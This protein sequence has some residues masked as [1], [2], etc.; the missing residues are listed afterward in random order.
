MADEISLKLEEREVTGKQV[1]HLRKD[2]LVPAV[3]HDHGKPSVHVMAPYLE[4][5]KVYREAGKHHPIS[6]S[7]GSQTYTALI[8]TAEFEPRK[9]R[10]NHVVFGAV[11][12]D[13]KVT[14]EIPIR[15]SEDIPAEKASLI[16]I[17][18]LESVEVEALP[19]DLPDEFI[20]NA[21]SLIEI[22]DKLT[23]ADIIAPA[24]V[25]IL[26]EPEHAIATVYEPSALAAANDA[27]GGDAEPE[28][29][30]DVESEE[31][32]AEAD[33]EN[34]ETQAEE[35]RPGGKEQKESHDQGTNPE[36]Q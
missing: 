6:L 12:A 27:A 1:K 16:V 36:K 9:H 11:S 14:T 23:V 33:A 26:T 5:F 30:A 35:I 4:V 24:S 3:I 8:K 34:A 7:V 19:K 22:G 28:D 31:G 21:S 25:T 18:Q 32:S 20:V 2:G 15:L 10:L 29:A 13:E 17:N